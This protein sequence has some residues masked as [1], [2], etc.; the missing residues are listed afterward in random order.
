MDVIICVP[1]P[2]SKNRE[3]DLAPVLNTGISL[4]P[5]LQKGQLVVESS[6]YRTT[7]TELAT[8]LERS[9]GKDQDFFWRISRTRGSR[10][11]SF[12]TSNIPKIIGAD[13]PEAR[14]LAAAVYEGV[15][16]DVIPLTPVN[17]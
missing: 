8:V 2:L 7:D 6:T 14:E 5:Y 10:N 3:P 11:E 17:G 4:V 16:S 9:A 13:T 1:T 12:C 15:I